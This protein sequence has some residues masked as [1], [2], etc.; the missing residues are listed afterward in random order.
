M[1]SLS[2]LLALCILIGQLQACATR[3]VNLVD[4]NHEAADALLL[5]AG[6]SLDKGKPILVA[7]IMDVADL[8]KTSRFGLITADMLAGRLAQQGYTVLEIKLDRENLYTL[9][10]TGEMLL[11]NELRNLSASF[12]AQAVLIGTYAPAGEQV[13]VSAKLVRAKDS[14]IIAAED[15]R[16]QGD[17]VASLIDPDLALRTSS[18]Y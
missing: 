8:T 9:T 6:A 15:Y 11:S 13:Y 7:T 17:D 1:R 12:G 18:W 3:N 5:K 16:L 14:V 2:L 4:R 10:G